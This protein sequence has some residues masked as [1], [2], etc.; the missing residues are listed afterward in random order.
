MRMLA[1]SAILLV[2]TACNERRPTPAEMAAWNRQDNFG[3]GLTVLWELVGLA[4]VAF[5]VADIVW[6]HQGVDR[7]W[8]RSVGILV[9]VIGGFMVIPTAPFFVALWSA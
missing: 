3:V 6:R 9:L 8:P 2:A 1:L 5:G 4:A 7:S